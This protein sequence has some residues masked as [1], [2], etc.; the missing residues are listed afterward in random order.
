MKKLLIIFFTLSGMMQTSAGQYT[1]VPIYDPPAPG[2]KDV[3]IEETRTSSENG[4]ATL[5]NVTKPEMWHF[6]ATGD[7]TR[8]AVI[9]CPGGGY[10][11]QAYEHEGTEVAKWLASLG[12]QAFVLKYRLPDKELFTD[13]PYIPLGDARQAILTVRQQADQFG[14][15]P[16]KI[17]IMG[18]SA[19][20]HL[21]ATASVLFNKKIPFAQTGPE[22]R[23]DFSIL[24]YPVISMT[25]EFTHQGSKQALLGETPSPDM[26]KL[27]SAE[28][29]VNSA[30]PPTFILHAEDDEGVAPQNTR[31]YAKALRKHDVE[32]K[33]IIL[34]EGG[35]GFGFKKESPAF[36][37]TE[38]LEEWLNEK[39]D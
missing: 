5:K 16:S 32:V 37:W 2:S 7:T 31:A 11:A 26:E 4:T 3:E 18:F 13:A 20:G 1:P 35:H 39:F 12:Y 34:P 17:G 24:I 30:T 25:D 14:V 8:P 10:Q 29:Q 19:G 21:A 27:F 23:P 36:K 28:K 38:Y 15:D 6:E 33:E 22:V 9:I